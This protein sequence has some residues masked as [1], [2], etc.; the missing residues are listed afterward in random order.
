LNDVQVAFNKLFNLL[1]MGM[2]FA[3]SK[4][5]NSLSQ[6]SKE[7][8]EAYLIDSLN[9]IFLKIRPVFKKTNKLIHYWIDDEKIISHSSWKRSAVATD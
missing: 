7:P 4:H 1:I 5:N 9:S 3:T 6:D 8:L 2:E